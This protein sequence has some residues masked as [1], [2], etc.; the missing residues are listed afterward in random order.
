MKT[1]KNHEAQKPNTKPKPKTLSAWM[2]LNSHGRV[3]LCL[4]HDPL[5]RLRD[6]SR[7][8]GITERTAHSIVVDLEHK[9]AITRLR[10]GR[11]NRYLIHATDQLL[12]LLEVTFQ[13][14]DK[15]FVIAGDASERSTNRSS[16]PEPGT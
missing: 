1:K 9:G 14:P 15:H 4:A 11:C 10:Q 7:R 5:V 6:L 3:L 2:F 13:Q 12:N 8:V 16:S